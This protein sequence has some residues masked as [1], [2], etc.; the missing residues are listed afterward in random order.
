MAKYRHRISGPILDRV[1]LFV[2]VSAIESEK[3][4]LTSNNQPN[5]ISSEEAKKQVIKARKIQNKR[6]KDEEK[7]SLYTNSQMRNADVKKYCFLT[8]E[9]ENLLKLAADKFDFSARSYF[10]LIKV[11]RTIADLKAIKN[12]LPLHM[13]E[14]LQYKQI[15]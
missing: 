15:I 3:L 9:A 12:I 5:R 6:F 1:D 7:R 8:S 2:P 10:R 13:A 4:S 14:A 11:A